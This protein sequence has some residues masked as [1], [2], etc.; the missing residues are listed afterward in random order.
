MFQQLF[1]EQET[2]WSLAPSDD[3][4]ALPGDAYGFADFTLSHSSGK[5]LGLELFHTWHG[6]PL[7]HRLHQLADLGMAPPLVIGVDRK[8]IKDPAIAAQ[9]E[10]SAYFQQW[11]FL[12]R[13]MPSPKAVLKIVEGL[14]C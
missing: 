4:I 14:H 9:L 13:D 3:F 5:V 1:H 10:A 7:T 8:L 6:G 11:G 12:F 2:D